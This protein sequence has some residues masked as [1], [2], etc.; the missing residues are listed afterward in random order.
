M[1]F[2]I[3]VLAGFACCA[4]TAVADEIGADFF[5]SKI[6]PVLVKHCYECHSIGTAEGDL[7]LDLKSTTRAGGGRGPAVVP[8]HPDASVLLTAITH[9][10]PDLK[11]PPKGPKLS[12]DVIADFKKWIQIGAP[13]PRIEVAADTDETW[14]GFQAAK[15]HWAYQPLV[16]S[17]PPETHSDWPLNGVDQYVFEKL[18]EHGIA[19]SPDAAPRADRSSSTRGSVSRSRARRPA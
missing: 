16:A 10:D 18:T 4:S 3:H 1:R 11:M 8:E 17:K 15:D 13:D 12:A 9:A 5:E 14:D 7:R 19:P 2:A 6:R